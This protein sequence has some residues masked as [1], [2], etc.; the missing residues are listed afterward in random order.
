MYALDKR[1][2]SKCKIFRLLTARMKITKFFVSFFKS[3]VSFSL[4]FAASFS[5][6]THSFSEIFLL[7]HY[8]L[9]TKR[10]HQCTIFQTFGC[11]NEGSP[12]PSSPCQFWN[13]EVRIYSNFASLF[14]VMKSNFSVCF[15]LK[16]H[17]LW[18]KLVVGGKFSKFFM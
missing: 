3:Q 4:N 12:I 11:S 13:H 7:K 8:M 2:W 9:W 10:S 5:V 18:A 17:M 14:S 16:P 6:M 15:Y 1:I